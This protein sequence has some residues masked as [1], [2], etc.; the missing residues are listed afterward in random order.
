[1]DNLDV[2]STLVGTDTEHLVFNT[3][4]TEDTLCFSAEAVPD[5]DVVTPVRSILV[6]THIATY[7]VPAA[8][9]FLKVI[10]KQYVVANRLT[11]LRGFAASVASTTTVISS[12]HKV[13]K[14]GLSME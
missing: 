12:Q 1:M 3:S 6:V 9:H 11:I 5:S 14:P 2:P 13:W 4:S 10:R 8:Q 7:T